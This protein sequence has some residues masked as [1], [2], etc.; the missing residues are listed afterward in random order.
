MRQPGAVLLPGIQ[1]A[2]LDLDDTS[3][4]KLA[5][6]FNGKLPMENQIQG[7]KVNQLFEES[8]EALRNVMKGF[9][10]PDEELFRL[11]IEKYVGMFFTSLKDP[12][13]PLLEFKVT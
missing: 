4:V 12:A 3:S 9:S 11:K 7:T 10:I 6:E 13:L 2:H 8:L 1:I 5:T